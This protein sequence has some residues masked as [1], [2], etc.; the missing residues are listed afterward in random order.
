MCV[1]DFKKSGFF[2]LWMSSNVYLGSLLY[3]NYT[4]AASVLLFSQRW[5]HVHPD[6]N[7]NGLVCIL[8]LARRVF[9]TQ[10][11]L[12]GLHRI[13]ITIVW[14]NIV[15]LLNLVDTIW[16][17]LVYHNIKILILCWILSSVTLSLIAQP[18]VV[19]KTH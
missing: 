2:K 8:G 3:N 13:E 17:D 15:Y 1:L 12:K 5:C 19:T 18:L 10:N 6:W 11:K 4:S 9:S 14:N 16:H 7:S